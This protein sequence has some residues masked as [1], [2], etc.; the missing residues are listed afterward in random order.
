MTP[1]AFIAKWR[2]ATLNERAAA[3]SHFNDLCRLLGGATPSDADQ[4]A[5]SIAVGG[6]A[7][8]E[9]RDRWLNPPDLVQRVPEVVPG[10]P[11]HI[12]P[13]GAKA[14]AI[15][16]TRTL[17]VLYNTRRGP[18]APGSMGCTPPSIPPSPPPM[19]GPPVSRRQRCLPASSLSTPPAPA[20][21]PLEDAG[22]GGRATQAAR[23]DSTR[24]PC[25]QAAAGEA[26][27]FRRAGTPVFARPLTRIRCLIQ[28]PGLPL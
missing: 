9:A 5:Q 1:D 11:E 13:R 3:Q 21:P 14:A 22:P 23:C 15:L 24:H 27:N 7:L 19:A 8:V 12:L 28:R 4:R 6:S 10:F 25:T 18:R 17:A 2:G 26:G 16:K 20:A